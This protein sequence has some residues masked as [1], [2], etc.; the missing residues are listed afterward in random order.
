MEPLVELNCL[1]DFYGAL[2]TEKQ[3]GVLQLYC[4]EDMSL[5]EIANQMGVSRQAVL[6]NI[7]NARKR[8]EEYEE[9][10]GLIHRYRAITV[11]AEQCLKALEKNDTSAMRRSL[12][13]IMQIER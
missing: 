9:K 6:I 13:N 1:L 3:R 2:L 11:E 8:L 7:Q 12:E 5:S 4:E 10:L